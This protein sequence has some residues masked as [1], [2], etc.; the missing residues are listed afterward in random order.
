MAMNLFRSKDGKS[1]LKGGL[2]CFLPFSVFVTLIITL[3]TGCAPGGGVGPL[4]TIKYHQVGACNGY[5]QGNNAV[6][7]GPNSAYVVF[8]IEAIDNSQPSIDFHFDPERLYIN[9]STRRF[10]S[11]SLTF[12]RDL[13]VIGIVPVTVPHG[14][15]R[16]INGFAVVIV[17]T[18]TANGSAEAHQTSYSLLY[19]TQS[20]D[21]GI[22]MD[23]TNATQTT[24][25]QTDGCRA[26]TLQ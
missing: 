2:K 7:A 18:S 11:T 13:G 19:D 12:A 26:M 17:S 25:P 3:L 6:A 22:F 10:V 5:V 24:W 20:S 9:Q 8:K 23:K 21:P 14:N 15:N 4:A 1:F 16:G